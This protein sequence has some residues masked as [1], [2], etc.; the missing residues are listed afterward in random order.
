MGSRFELAYRFAVGEA[1]AN[2]EKHMLLSRPRANKTRKDV[3]R[4]RKT[5][6]I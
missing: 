2:D 3:K 6:W 5:S 1:V 4:P